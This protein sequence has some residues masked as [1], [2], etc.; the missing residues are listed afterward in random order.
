MVPS[1]TET[2]MAET[3]EG[4]EGGRASEKSSG[5]RPS[6]L[7]ICIPVA[8]R[9]T[10]LRKEML[11]DKVGPE[12]ISRLSLR[13][14]TQSWTIMMIDNKYASA[15]ITWFKKNGSSVLL[16]WQRTLL[17]V[18][19][20]G[21]ASSFRKSNTL[22]CVGLLEHHTHGQSPLPTPRHTDKHN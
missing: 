6:R 14:L 21:W 10:S 2:K 3:E 17:Q 11:N 5:Y 20:G 19:A 13:Y 15:N 16:L 4:E 8:S 9:V 18:P 22:F 12:V 1:L 7:L